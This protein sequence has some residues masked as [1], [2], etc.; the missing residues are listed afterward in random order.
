M[1]AKI[2]QPTKN[3]MQSGQSKNFWLLEFAAKQEQFVEPLMGWTGV[4]DTLYEVK[5]K[6][7]SKEDAIA[8]AERNNVSFE[9]VERSLKTIK[10]KSYSANFAFDK[11]S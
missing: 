9:L 5:L 1:Y 6:F 7:D 8:Y 11:V 4:K 10:P 2:Y 3:A